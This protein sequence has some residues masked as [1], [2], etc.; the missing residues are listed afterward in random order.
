MRFIDH[1]LR[2]PDGPS[3]YAKLA[4]AQKSR[5]FPTQRTRPVAPTPTP[6]RRKRSCRLNCRHG[7]ARRTECDK[8]MPRTDISYGP[9]LA[10]SFVEEDR[11]KARA[12]F[13]GRF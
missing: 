4:A 8:Q 1:E 5:G 11:P 10:H 6:S 9:R 3:R 2:A 7:G 12:R 13:G